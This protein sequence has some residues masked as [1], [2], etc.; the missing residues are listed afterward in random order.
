MSTSAATQ[1]NAVADAYATSAVHARGL[2]LSLLVEALG[3]KPDWSVLD[4]G[5]G[6]GHASFAVAPHVGRVTAVDVAERMLE[7]SAAQAR[8]RGLHNISFVRDSADH[9]RFNSGTFD[10][11]FTRLSAHHWPIPAAGVSEM[12]RVLKPGAPLV[13]ID[14]VGFDDPAMDT[15]LN[16]LELLRDPSHVRN[17]TVGDWSALLEQNV[18]RVEHVE[19]WTIALDTEDWLRRAATVSWRADACRQLLVEAPEDARQA[20]A[21]LDGGRQFALPAA[22]IAARRT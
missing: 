3:A 19:R 11:A 9:L 18:C 22:L 5:T 21:I 2:D 15:F 13:F 14:T 10:G 20:L 7:T 1:F 4:V 6:A 16:T 17:K 12:A 8:A